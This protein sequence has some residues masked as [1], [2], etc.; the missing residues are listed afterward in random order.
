MATIVTSVTWRGQAKIHGENILGGG[1]GGGGNNSSMK[2]KI[3][4]GKRA[5]IIREKERKK[6][7]SC[8]KIFTV[9]RWPEFGSPRI[10]VGLL[11]ESYE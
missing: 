8:P 9:F 6:K 5:K 3:I 1:G 7:Q 4:K 11:N 2:E 10:K